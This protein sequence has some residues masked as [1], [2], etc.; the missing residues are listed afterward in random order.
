MAK[1]VFMTK[2]KVSAYLRQ[3]RQTFM[4]V[5]T[6]HKKSMTKTFRKLLRNPEYECDVAF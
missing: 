2:M 6:H 4:L 3:P 5:L 1:P